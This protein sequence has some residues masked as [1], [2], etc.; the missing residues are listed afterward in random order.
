[1]FNENLKVPEPGDERLEA[2]LV[3]VLS[4][5]GSAFVAVDA[6]DECQSPKLRNDLV[7]ALLRIQSQVPVNIFLTSR[8][9]QGTFQILRDC[10]HIGKELL[11]SQDDL[12]MYLSVELLRVCPWEDAGSGILDRAKR[13]IMDAA[14]GM[15]VT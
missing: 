3:S 1:M 6:L 2:A 8:P 9:D 11:G 15:Y 14:N 13:D 7:T 12:D 4:G 5:R 10:P